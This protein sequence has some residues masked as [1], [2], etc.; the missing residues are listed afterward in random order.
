M[1]NNHKE[2]HF[3]SQIF[4][5][6]W[7]LHI[8]LESLPISSS[9]HISLLNQWFAKIFKQKPLEITTSIDHLMHIPTA[10]IIALFLAKHGVWNMILQSPQSLIHWA[11]I[12]GIANVITGFF[13]FLRKKVM[14]ENS[15]V[16]RLVHWPLYVGFFTTSCILLSLYWVPQGV[17]EYISS[18]DA[19]FI[20]LAQSIA[21]LPGVSRLASTYAMGAWMGFAPTL[22]F[23]FSL[24]I[25]LFLALPAIAAALADKTARLS[26]LYKTSW[27]MYP[28]LGVASFISYCLLELILRS[29]THALFASCGW[30]MLALTLYVYKRK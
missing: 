25:E 7:S 1:K 2:I 22:S 9:G 23:V 19:V 8:I 11:T 13:Y 12:V 5:A 20:G 6:I 3:R 18:T 28:V 10:T 30:Y 17:R 26:L 29:S 16:R 24:L 21:L 14:S 27:M 4:G 15:R